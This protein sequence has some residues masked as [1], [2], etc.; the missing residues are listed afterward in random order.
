MVLLRIRCAR[1]EQS[2]LFD[3]FK[4]FDKNEGIYTSD[5]NSQQRPSY[6][7]KM[8]WI[9]IKSK[10]HYIPKIYNLLAEEDGVHGCLD[11]SYGGIALPIQPFPPDTGQVYR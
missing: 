4:V 6:V 7:R 3:L 8:I 11:Y 9:T 2:L 5:F 10:Y 1:R